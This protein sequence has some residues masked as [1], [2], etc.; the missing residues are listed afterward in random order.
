MFSSNFGISYETRYCIVLKI[1]NE[2]NI[3]GGISAISTRIMKSFLFTAVTFSSWQNSVSD[4]Y[5][6]IVST[7]SSPFWVTNG[8]DSLSILRSFT[9]RGSSSSAKLLGTEKMDGG[10]TGI[11]DIF[12]D[13]YWLLIY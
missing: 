10:S 4:S 1:F 2:K 11:L 6:D 3:P 9:F 12:H 8:L 7:C 13:Q 5:D